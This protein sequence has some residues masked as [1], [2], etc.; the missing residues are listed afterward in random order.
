MVRAHNGVITIMHVT[1][2]D[3][4]VQQ[5]R[6]V[7]KHALVKVN[8][9]ASQTGC[10]TCDKISANAPSKFQPDRIN[11]QQTFKFGC[12]THIATLSAVMSSISP[13][14]LGLT[15]DAPAKALTHE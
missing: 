8:K 10:N 11:L 5:W 15:I 14:E 13:R 12:R 2:S 3:L 6:K 4:D 7:Y 1:H 9:A